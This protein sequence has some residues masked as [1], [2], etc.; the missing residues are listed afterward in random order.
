M[1]KR[2]KFWWLRKGRYHNRCAY[3]GRLHR[4]WP[5]TPYDERCHWSVSFDYISYDEALVRV[6]ATQALGLGEGT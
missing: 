3:Y 5:W 6:A 4:Q 1:M 2:L